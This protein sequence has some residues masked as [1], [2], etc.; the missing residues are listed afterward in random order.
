MAKAIGAALRA[1][2]LGPSVHAL[3][4]DALDGTTLYS[5]AA[6]DRLPPAST[7]KLLTGAAVLAAVGAQNRIRTTV[8]SGSKPGQVVIVGGGDPTLSAALPGAPTLYRNAARLSALAAQASRAVYPITSIVVDTSAF[9]GPVEAPGW[10]PEDVPS[11]YA[12]AVTALVV[13]GGRP[14]GGGDQR[15]E[16]PA[17]EAGR[18][19][20]TLLGKPDL[21]VTAGSAPGNATTLATVYSAP[22][23]DLVEQM[24][25]NSD[26]T[27]A[28][29]VA[30]QVARAEHQ[31]L[32]FAGGVSAVRSALRNAGVGAPTGLV[33]GSGLS[34]KDRLSPLVL[35][36]VLRA[37]CDGKHPLLGQLISALP[38]AA[39]EGTLSARYGTS[40]GHVAAGRVRA[41]TGTL[42]RVVTLAGVVTDTSGR[43]LVFAVMIDQ[44]S[45]AAPEPAEKALDEAIATLAA[46]TCH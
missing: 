16:H 17:L 27:I 3:V 45:P 30:R 36:A 4:A 2:D 39:W 14:A 35:V 6:A 23:V 38:V 26:N 46:C 21:A 20:A 10:A 12:S 11:T 42:T 25:T 43:L 34:T 37:A 40:R 41:K 15:S 28:E 19:F 1:P 24:L 32:S 8:V 44:A 13:D 29:M 7:A 9:S 33:D 22:M 31:P 5:R 18:A